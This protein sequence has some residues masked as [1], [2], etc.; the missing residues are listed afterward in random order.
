MSCNHTYHW[1]STA[2]FC[3]ITDAVDQPNLTNW[4]KPN[5][6]S[7]LSDKNLFVLGSNRKKNIF[8]SL[9]SLVIEKIVNASLSVHLYFFFFLYNNESTLCSKWRLFVQANLQGIHFH[10][11]PHAQLSSPETAILT[12]PCPYKPVKKTI[13]LPST[14]LQFA[15]V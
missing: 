15:S 8:W 6:L 14:V 5:T 7:I 13:N 2:L 11:H 4:G 12:K 10:I 3:S 1:T 9:K